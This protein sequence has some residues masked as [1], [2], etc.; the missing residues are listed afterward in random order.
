MPLILTEGSKKTDA[1]VSQGLCVIPL[2]GVFSW[3][4]VNHRGGL[5][6]LGDWENIALKGKGRRARDMPHGRTG[7]QDGVPV[8]GRAWIERG[9]NARRLLGRR[10]AEMPTV[11]VAVR[12][13]G[14]DGA[15]GAAAKG[16][17]AIDKEIADATRQQTVD[18]VLEPDPQLCAEYRGAY[19]AERAV[20]GVRTP[21]GGRPW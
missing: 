10:A 3:R 16:L 20:R 1:G 5:T 7:A 8:D 17:T 11:T 19:R 13:A 15:S 18:L 6:A 14:A 4:G 9:C 12:A 21:C 2:P